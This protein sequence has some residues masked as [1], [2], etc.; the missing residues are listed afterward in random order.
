MEYEKLTYTNELG[1]S[2]EFG[3][4]ST[5]YCNVSKDA[6]G[7]AGVDNIIYS[8][9]SAQQHGDTF[10]GQRIEAREIGVKGVIKI[11]DKAQ[12]I[13]MRRKALRILNP[14]LKG[15]LKYEY[16]GFTKVIDVRIDD[17]PD[18]YR[19]VIFLQYEIAF[20]ALNP[21]W[22]D[23]SETKE[24]IASWVGALEF[25]TEIDEDDSESMIFGYR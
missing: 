6:T 2:I 20:K 8:T 25:P 9:N 19:G 16:R 13:E 5:F 21:F 3:V 15:T 14:E 1:N 18:F 10:T 4:S 22:R 11:K 24:E 7:L 23:E 17:R 12:A